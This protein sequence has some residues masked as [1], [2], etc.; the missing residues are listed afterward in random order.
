MRGMIATIIN[1][2]ASGIVLIVADPVAFNLDS[3]LRKLVMTSTVFA[4]FGL[5][6]YLKQ[7]PLPDDEDVVSV[8]SNGRELR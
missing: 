6:N 3:G 8:T 7:H 1:G 2:F 4:L 5:G